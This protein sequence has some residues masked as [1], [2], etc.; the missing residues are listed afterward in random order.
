MKPKHWSRPAS[1][2]FSLLFIAIMCF[3]L[4]PSPIPFGGAG[5]A[6]AA[7]TY[8]NQAATKDAEV[9]SYYPTTNYGTTTTLRVYNDAVCPNLVRVLIEFDISDFPSG[10]TQETATLSVYVGDY[11]TGSSGKTVDCKR[12]TSSWT[13]AG[14]TWDTK[15]ATTDTDKASATAPATGNWMS[16]NVLALSQD[17]IASRSGIFSVMLILNP[18]SGA[19]CCPVAWSAEYATVSLRPKIEITYGP[20]ITTNAA[21][22]ITTSSATLNGNVTSI[23]SGGNVTSYGFILNTTSVPSNPGN[24]SP[25]AQTTYTAGNWTW[26]GVQYAAGTAFNSDGNVTGLASC[27]R[28]YFRAGGYNTAGWAWGDEL[29]FDTLPAELQPPAGAG[30]IDG[31]QSSRIKVEISENGGGAINNYAVMFDAL[32]NGS[33]VEEDSINQFLYRPGTRYL[34]THDR[35]YIVNVSSAGVV[36]I[37]Q[38]DEDDL[39]LSDAVTLATGLVGD[40]HDGGSVEILQHQSGALSGE[41]G[42]VLVMY[43]NRATG[44]YS[45]RSDNA[46]DISSWGA[47]NTITTTIANF[48]YPTVIELA[49]GTVMG[50]YHM[51]GAIYYQTMTVASNPDDDTWGTAQVLASYEASPYYKLWYDGTD[52]HFTF[53]HIDAPPY[54]SLAYHD[55]MYAKMTGFHTGVATS[56]STN[57]LIASAATFQTWTMA[58]EWWVLN[59]TDNTI[60]KVTAVNSEGNLTIDT[61]IFTNGEGFLVYCIKDAAGTLKHL[62]M[63]GSAAAHIPQVVHTSAVSH[64]SVIW[65]IKVDGSNNPNIVYCDGTVLAGDFDIFVATYSGGAWNVADTGVN[66]H[67]FGTLGIL[68]AGAELDPTNVNLMCAA[69]DDISGHTQIQMY[70]NVSGTWYLANGGNGTTAVAT[71]GKITQ[72]SPGDN[73]R[74]IYIRNGAGHFKYLWFYSERYENA[75]IPSGWESMR[76]AYPGFSNNDNLCLNKV[77]RTDF[78]DLRLTQSDGET[79]QPSSSSGKPWIQEKT[80]S[81]RAIVWW[82]CGNVTAASLASFTTNL[83]GSNNDLT[84][85]AK[86]G[87]DGGNNI[88]VTYTNPGTA[89]YGLSVG[90]KLM[91]SSDT[92][93]TSTGG[94]GY[95]YWQKYTATA[96]TCGYVRVLTNASGNVKVAV[97]DDDGAG[98]IPGTRLAK[99]DTSAAVVSGWNAIKLESTFITTASGYW[100]AVTGDDTGTIRY[101]ATGTDRYIA[102]TYATWV[103]AATAPALTAF[104]YEIFVQAYSAVYTPTVAV[105]GNDIT[106]TLSTDDSSVINSTATMVKTAVDGYG[107]STALVSVANAGGNDGSG[108]VT[109]MGKTALSGGAAAPTTSVYVYFG[110]ASATNANTQAIMDAQFLACDGFD[111]GTTL[112]TNKWTLEA[113][114]VDIAAGSLVLTG[115]GGTDGLIDQKAANYPLFTYVEFRMRMLCSDTTPGPFYH[116][117]LR[118][119]NSASDC[120]LI[121]PTD[122]TPDQMAILTGNEASY[123]STTENSQGITS[124]HNYSAEWISGSVKGYNDVNWGTQKS[125]SNQLGTTL[126]TN[127]AN[128]PLGLAFLEGDPGG[129]IYIDWTFARTITNPWPKVSALTQELLDISNTPFSWS[130]GVVQP[131]QTYWANGADPDPWPLEAADCWGNLTNN[132]SFAVDI[133]ASMGN[134]IGGTTWTI[135]SSPGTNVFTIKIGIAGK[136]NVGN[137]TTLSNTPVAWITSMVAGNMTR[138]TMVFYTPTNAPQFAD[139]VLKSG[140]VTFEAEAS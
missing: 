138:W 77:S 87:G 54:N 4:L 72:A 67:I 6:S 17:A 114:G 45:I 85:T 129:I 109:A 32:Y 52:I 34:G 108:L 66:T 94:T 13:E 23:Y 64:G 50:F 1:I 106:A 135:G 117:G 7:V 123:T 134:M 125:L 49:N 51:H 68:L 47:I 30:W 60:A 107:A 113:G 18:E 26:A 124:W 31:G 27:T 24:V 115:S 62:P 5:V 118:E 102:N 122:T 93:D 38:W 59:T 76:L 99:Q 41:N 83:T 95:A 21:G 29:Y 2:A 11:C 33:V 132:S 58:A 15:P 73:F 127:V 12:T 61:N 71:D 69:V 101:K 44:M 74:P 137:F 22:S 133:S 65:D 110:D 105:S 20:S 128:E 88:T 57:E 40:D 48:E 8:T 36:S 98:G 121:Y 56:T 42:T 120:V 91:G 43:C 139:G 126:T 130:V 111:N 103:W 39:T 136:A 140:N 70:E 78:G 84:Y 9:W 112:D 81:W 86:T 10:I 28:L 90:T 46:E 100:V 82:N 37:R 14:V 16:F 92:G 89:N 75:A 53:M 80:D 131:S 116:L 19:N 63:D 25:S 55:V 104:D 79:L 3:T 96:G 35:T 97:Y 119:T